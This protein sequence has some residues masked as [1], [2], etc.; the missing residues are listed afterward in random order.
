M[1]TGWV[2]LFCHP[3]G[4]QLAGP[5]H[6]ACASQRCIASPP[7]CVASLAAITTGGRR[8]DPRLA[9]LLA[10]GV[11]VAA[12]GDWTT[13]DVV[14]WLE[15]PVRLSCRDCAPFSWRAY[16]AGMGVLFPSL[17]L[18]APSF[19]ATAATC[20]KQRTRISNEHK[21]FPRFPM[22]LEL[23]YTGSVNAET[24]RQVAQ[25]CRIVD[26]CIRCLPSHASEQH[27]D[28]CGNGAKFCSPA[29]VLVGTLFPPVPG[30]SPFAVVGRW[31]RLSA[32]GSMRSGHMCG[33]CRDHRFT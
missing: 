22:A 16:P 20:E 7:G 24:R 8:P 27:G 18:C 5:T 6:A 3:H 12:V 32:W 31:P 15:L 25:R 33:V 4:R 29:E 23:N 21:N 13:A 2:V 28:D 30:H 1:Q 26:V 11:D 14:R 17:R 9:L 19:I 10:S